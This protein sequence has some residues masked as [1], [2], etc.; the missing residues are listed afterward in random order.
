MKER[1]D[2]WQF[3]ISLTNKVI[4]LEKFTKSNIKT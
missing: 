4:D 1:K 2:K 3:K